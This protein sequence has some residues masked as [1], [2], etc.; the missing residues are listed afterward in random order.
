MNDK[1]RNVTE[2]LYLDDFLDHSNQYFNPINFSERRT[3]Y[4]FVRIELGHIFSGSSRKFPFTSIF[5][6]INPSILIL[7][8]INQYED[9]RERKFFESTRKDIKRKDPS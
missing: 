4:K 7:I 9:R 8:M 1:F 2:F 3:I 5:I 6:L